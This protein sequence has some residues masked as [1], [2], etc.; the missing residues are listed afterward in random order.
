MV[1][2]GTKSGSDHGGKLQKKRLTI[3]TAKRRRDDAG[4]TPDQM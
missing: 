3:L 4:K 2:Q 1:T